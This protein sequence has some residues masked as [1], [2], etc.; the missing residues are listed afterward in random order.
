ML[1]R[2]A[3]FPHAP[4]AQRSSLAILHAA[5]CRHR[6]RRRH[7]PRHG[8]QC[9]ATAAPAAKW[10]ARHK[11]TSVEEECTVYHAPRLS[12]RAPRGEPWSCR[13]QNAQPAAAAEG[14]APA[15]R[16]THHARRDA[17]TP[18]QRCSAA[19][20]ERVEEDADVQ[21]VERPRG[22]KVGDDVSV[23]QRFE[24]GTT[25]FTASACRREA[26]P[27]HHQRRGARA[28]TGSTVTVPH[29]PLAV[30]SPL[31]CPCGVQ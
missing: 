23:L 6:P 28:G 12:A 24:R 16:F 13:A 9:A 18:P 8:W 3:R 15:R 26:H 4:F 30:P 29:M 1:G 25:R 2:I 20:L 17:P 19:R 5:G 14:C 7:S 21:V 11:P 10:S 27:R 22:I 31:S